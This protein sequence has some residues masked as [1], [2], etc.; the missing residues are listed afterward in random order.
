M[1][2]LS[3]VVLTYVLGPRA[4][5]TPITAGNKIPPLTLDSLEE[6]IR[7]GE[8]SVSGLKPGNEAKIVWADTLP[9]KTPY[10]VV[11]LHGFSASHM[12]GSP[13][14]ENFAKAYGMNLYLARL[15]DHGRI[16][17]NSFE[18]LTPDAL[19]DS[20]E[21]AL[22]IGKLLGDSIIVMS[23]STGSTLSIVLSKYHPEIHSF[24]MFSPN[25]DLANSLSA[26]SI[27]PWGDQLTKAVLGGEYN[28]IQYNEE[29]K[30]YWNS[31][32]QYKGIIALKSLLSE[33]MTPE[34]FQTINQPLFLGY[35]FKDKKVQD[36]VVSVERILDFYDEVSTPPAEKRKIA[37]P[38]AGNHVISSSIQSKSWQ[39]LQEDV[40]KF[41]SEVLH[42]S[43]MQ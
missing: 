30:K 7:V 21:K 5:F 25:I 12:E 33:Y 39:E 2:V 8:D 29:A 11:Y 37:Y 42:L 1:I 9:K 40:I 14:H 18:H 17:T 4:R 16:D 36:N 3:A 10:A 31:V 43:K 26:L 38:D 19:F 41:G 6:W 32:Y 28:R 13:I 27:K 34:Y 15:E 22:E 20:A 35:Y 23:C 24:I